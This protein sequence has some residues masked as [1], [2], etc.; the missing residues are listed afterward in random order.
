MAR[1][2]AD[3]GPDRGLDPLGRNLG[4]D[5]LDSGVP[6]GADQH[7]LPPRGDRRADQTRHRAGYEQGQPPETALPFPFSVALTL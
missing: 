6:P 3:Q 5:R 2:E 1:P 4:Q 7:I